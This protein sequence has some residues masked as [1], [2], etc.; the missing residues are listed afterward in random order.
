MSATR[1]PAASLSLVLGVGA[2]QRP[3]QVLRG[4]GRQVGS[5]WEP[6]RKLTEAV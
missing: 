3:L 4:A 6:G 1:S 2:A 5:C